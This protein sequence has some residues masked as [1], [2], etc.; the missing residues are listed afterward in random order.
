MSIIVLH[1]WPSMNLTG[2]EQT[3]FTVTC[4]AI[5]ITYVILQV[6][7]SQE[8]EHFL[9][10]PLGLLY[11]EVTAGSLVKVDMQGNIVDRGNTA[12]GINKAGFILHAA[13]HAAR[14][15]V[16]CIVHTH[17]PAVIAVSYSTSFSD[18]ISSCLS[19]KR[20]DK[21]KNFGLRRV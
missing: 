5:E 15:D 7:I 8:L 13:I 20:I 2:Y 14:P 3:L 9:I 17:V 21:I 10:N 12:L 19:N 18:A 16:K 6:R 4:T 1:H 11:N